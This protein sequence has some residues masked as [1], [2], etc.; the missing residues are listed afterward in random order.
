MEEPRTDPKDT[1]SPQ[2][3]KKPQEEIA[4]RASELYK[5]AKPKVDELVTRAKPKVDELVTKAKPRVEEAGKDAVRYVREHESDIK[6]AASL[7]ARYRL[8]GP[9]RLVFDAMNP[10]RSQPEVEAESK[11]AACE[12][13]NP[14]ASKFCNDCGSRL[15]PSD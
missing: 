14:P 13:L 6:R 1:E 12:H 7:A 8:P 3:V 4:A 2:P 15:T 11:C 5:D 10:N 9:L